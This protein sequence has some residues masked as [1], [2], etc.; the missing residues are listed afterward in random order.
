M[1]ERPGMPMP[2]AGARPPP[3]PA[4]REDEPMDDEAR[5]AALQEKQRKWLQLSSKRYGEKRKFGFVEQQKED[6]PAEVR[7]ATR[8]ALRAVRERAS[9]A[10]R[11]CHLRAH[12][13]LRPARAPPHTLPVSRRQPRR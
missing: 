13:Q 12:E 10:I 6:M 9:G 2:P 4:A 3:P 8:D 11:L 5:L 1:A 7:R